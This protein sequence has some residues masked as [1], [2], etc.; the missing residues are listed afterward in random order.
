MDLANDLMASVRDR[1]SPGGQ[2]TPSGAPVWAELYARLSAAHAAR[3]VLLQEAEAVPV[4]GFSLWQSKGRTN[5]S[6]DVN[7][8]DSADGKGAI[9][10]QDDTAGAIKTG[11]RGLP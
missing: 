11:G 2:R 3:G 10:N 5:P 1:V 6:G 8:N 7:R 4:G 9:A